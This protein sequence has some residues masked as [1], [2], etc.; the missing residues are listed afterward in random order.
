MDFFD[1]DIFKDFNFQEE[2]NTE[3]QICRAEL[4]LGIK[5]PE[6]LRKIL[7]LYNGGSG[8]IGDYYLD[9]WSLEDIIDFYQ[10]NM[11]VE[12]NN[13]VPF[14]SDGCGMAFALKKGS[15]EIRI[16][17]MDS[18]EYKYSK[19]CGNNFNKFVHD[20]YSGDLLEY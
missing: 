3:S 14:A 16:I 18:L 4:E 5:F 2:Q 7:L 13:L 8:E 19:V 12:E 10:E 20:M 17:P 6:E 9:L 15:S 1:K 11:E